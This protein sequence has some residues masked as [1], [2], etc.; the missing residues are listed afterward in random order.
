MSP[1]TPDRFDTPSDELLALAAAACDGTITPDGAQRLQ[2]LLRDDPRARRFYVAYVDLHSRLLWRFRDGHSAS[3][4]PS[5]ESSQSGGIPVSSSSAPVPL[6]ARA[7]RQSGKAGMRWTSPVLG[8]LRAA[9]RRVKRVHGDVR[10]T[11][12][13]L[14]IYMFLFAGA[15]AG[16]LAVVVAM[17]HNVGLPG[18]PPEVAKTLPAATGEG[19]KKIPAPAPV[20]M[21]ARL[22][23]AVDCAWSSETSVPAIGGDLAAGRKLALESGLAEIRFKNGARAVLQGPATL[24]IRSQSCAYLSGGKVAVTAEG[25]KARGFVIGAPGMKYTDLGTEFGVLVA[26]DGEQEVHVFRGSVQAEEVADEKPQTTDEGPG[27]RDAGHAPTP[28]GVQSVTGSDGSHPSSPA[29]Q[30]PPAVLSADQALRVGSSGAPG[31]PARRIVRIAADGKQFVRAAQMDQIVAEQSLEFRRWKKMSDNFRKQPDVLVY[32]DFQA[33]EADRTML[34]NRAASGSKL[35][36]RIE[37]AKWAD[38]P[39]PGKQALEFKGRDDR[40]RVDIPD[41]LEAVTAVVW[42]RLDSLP[43]PFNSI[44]MSDRWYERVGACHWQIISDEARVVFEPC[45]IAKI[46]AVPPDFRTIVRSPSLARGDFGAWTQLAVVYD[47]TAGTTAYYK[48]GQEIG[49][50]KLSKNIPLVFGPGQIAN[51]EPYKSVNPANAVRN[52]P[53]RISE[54]YLYSRALPAKEVKR[55][56]DD[57]VSQPGKLA[58]GGIPG[59]SKEHK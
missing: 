5:N 7:R 31:T 23:N 47:S 40:V 18:N 45:P 58:S 13:L 57:A 27:M 22:T 49:A 10:Y 50:E 59:E 38:G 52:L 53:A 41:S 8:L 55:L 4:L 17:F 6:S 28:Q 29:P 15:L 36:G 16:A 25:A 14:W 48:N 19:P 44:M 32:Y 11:V 37:G 54:L 1:D 12:A 21:V 24:E 46:A 42:I 2:S 35:D 26:K 56:Y 51:W 9:G 33:D 20:E 39:L 34:R 43:N 30:P 3:A